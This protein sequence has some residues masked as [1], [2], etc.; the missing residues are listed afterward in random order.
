M[1]PRENPLFRRLRRMHTAKVMRVE[2]TR[3]SRPTD[4]AK[5]H[6]RVYTREVRS[7]FLSFFFFFFFFPPPAVTRGVHSVRDG[8]WNGI[9]FRHNLQSTSLRI[10]RPTDCAEATTRSSIIFFFLLEKSIDRRNW[11][12]ARS[13][14]LVSKAETKRASGRSKLLPTATGT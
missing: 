3:Q 11:I 8:S 2:E 13:S 14:A 12:D 10:E 5:S 4:R 9:Q 1:I 7:F 6:A